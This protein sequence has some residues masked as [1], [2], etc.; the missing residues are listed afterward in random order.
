MMELRLKKLEKTKAY[1][2]GILKTLKNDTRR[3][4]RVIIAPRMTDINIE[5]LTCAVKNSPFPPE[6]K[7]LTSSYGKHL[8][9]FIKMNGI[10]C[11]V[12]LSG[13]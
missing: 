7:K 1:R 8:Y 12:V 13:I 11:I 10:P 9:V 2:E 6:K 4:K 5:D 3:R